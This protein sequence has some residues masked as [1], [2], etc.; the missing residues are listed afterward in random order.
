MMAI[1][2]STTVIHM[3]SRSQ[4]SKKDTWGPCRIFYRIYNN[5]RAGNS[6]T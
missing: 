1:N 2:P 3:H 5:C 4:E 6:A